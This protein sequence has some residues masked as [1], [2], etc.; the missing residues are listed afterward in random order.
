MIVFTFLDH[1]AAVAVE[2]MARRVVVG[3]RGLSIDHLRPVGRA[4][5]FSS[6]MVMRQ[7]TE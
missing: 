6:W 5:S 7:L 1:G 3:E 2:G 4:V